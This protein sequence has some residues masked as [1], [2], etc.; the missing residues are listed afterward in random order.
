MKNPILITGATG[1]LGRHLLE[2]LVSQEK[3]L[4]P[5]AL[6]RKASAWQRLDWTQAL[7]SV[8]VVEGS[9]TE[10]EKWRED[11]RL[12]GLRGI[13]HL[14]AVIRHSREDAEDLYRTNIEGLLNMVRLAAVHKCRIVFVSTSGTVGCFRSA[15]EW[16]DEHSPYCEKEV[17][18]WPYY[19][20]KIQAEQK[21]RE[22]AEQLGVELVIVRPPVLLGPGDHRFRATGHILRLLQ[23]RL[24]FLLKGGI[25]F[26]DVR[27]ATQALIRAMLRPNPRPVYHLSGTSCSIDEFFKMV[28]EISGVA[29]PRLRLPGSLARVVARASSQLEALLPKRGSP[30]LPD[31]VVFEMA[32]KYW[33]LRSCYSAEE[34]GFVSRDAHETISDTVQWLRK[35]HSELNKKR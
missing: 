33:G 4:Q 8:E 35:H 28:E 27:D 19:N 15:E 30:L 23:G 24:P 11:P 29:A 32:S 3:T 9:V 31:P 13:F 2:G 1:F 12:H 18:S 5:L 21:A 7:A 17:A 22:L 14:A 6:V 26:V 10:P 34:L 20:S 25:H 16:A